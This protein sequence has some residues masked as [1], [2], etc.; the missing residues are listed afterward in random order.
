MDLTPTSK[1][2]GITVAKCGVIKKS[3]YKIELKFCS[4]IEIP[5]YAKRDI[6]ESATGD[7]IVVQVNIGPSCC[8][9]PGTLTTAGAKIIQWIYTTEYA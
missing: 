4:R 9:L 6:I 5:I 2:V 7:I 1:N 8:Q 3:V